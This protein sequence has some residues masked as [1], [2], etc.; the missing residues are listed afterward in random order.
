VILGLLAE[1]PLSGYQIKKLVDIRFKFFW[2]ES[3]GQIFPALKS[4]AAQGYCEELP[5]EGARAARVYQ[6]TPSGREAL[7]HWLSQPVEKESLRLEIL[8]KTYFS[9][10]AAP[11]AMLTHLATFEESHSKQLHILNLFQAE[12]ERIPDEDENHGD[13]LRVIDFGQKANRAYLDWCRETKAY[14][15]RKQSIAQRRPDENQ[16]AAQAGESN[17]E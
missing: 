5:Q 9:G 1:Q 13:I 6:I 11:E 2:S 8:L 15:E 17:Q 4:L 7:V 12:L 3:F 10:Y 14:F 16:T